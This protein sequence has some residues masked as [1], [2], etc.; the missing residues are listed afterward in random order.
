[1]PRDAWCRGRGVAVSCRS[2][3]VE[4]VSAGVRL[5]PAADDPVADGQDRDVAQSLLGAEWVGSVSPS[6]ATM[7]PVIAP[8]SPAADAC[9][10][11]SGLAHR[12][13]LGAVVAAA[14]VRRDVV[15]LGGSHDEPFWSRDRVRLWHSTQGD[16]GL[17]CTAQAT[18][19][20]VMPRGYSSQ[21]APAT[22][23]TASTPLCRTC[24]SRPS[25]AYPLA[26]R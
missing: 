4:G 20:E 7:K 8:A 6:S 2:V 11:L 21:T 18:A 13:G 17:P 23:D 25:L 24:G 3:V 22:L 15:V 26:D 14:L 12:P 16:C 9:D 1:M 10:D 5:G 19:R